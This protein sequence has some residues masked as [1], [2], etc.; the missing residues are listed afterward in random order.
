MSAAFA[1]TRSGIERVVQA[2]RSARRPALGRLQLQ[3]LGQLQLQAQGP[4]RA[5]AQTR[6][7]ARWRVP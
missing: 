5:P 6:V 4:L 1:E 2:E 3:A 7:R